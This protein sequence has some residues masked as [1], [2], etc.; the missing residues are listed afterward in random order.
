M[1]DEISFVLNIYSFSIDAN[2]RIF[3]PLLYQMGNEISMESPQNL[4]NQNAK[5]KRKSGSIWF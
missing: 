5:S 4:Q 2:V 3:G 1:Q